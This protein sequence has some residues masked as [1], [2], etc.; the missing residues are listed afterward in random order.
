MKKITSRTRPLNNNFSKRANNNNNNTVNKLNNNSIV[1]NKKSS[2]HRVQQQQ[3]NKQV[4]LR[5]A[6]ASSVN[7]FLKP[8]KQQ[9]QVQQFIRRSPRM[10]KTLNNT[11]QAPHQGHFAAGNVV[12]S[13]AALNF[14]SAS[15]TNFFNNINNAN[16]TNPYQLFN[17]NNNNNTNRSHVGQST[18]QPALLMNSPNFGRNTFSNNS[19]SNFVPNQFMQQSSSSSHHQAASPMVP[20]NH[21]LQQSQQPLQGSKYPKR[22]KAIKINN[23]SNQFSSRQPYSQTVQPISS[24]PPVT[25]HHHQHHNNDVTVNLTKDEPRLVIFNPNMSSNAGA[26]TTSINNASNKFNKNLMQFNSNSLKFN[27]CKISKFI[28]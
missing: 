1:I 11:K 4:K 13:S 19:N 28:S 20:P 18:Q 24:R 2:R 5:L 9:A 16:Y 21:Q 22:S 23:T 26:T 27:N 7:I 3:Q 12:S 6:T 10:L 8:V 17:N 14:P 15:H 25:Y